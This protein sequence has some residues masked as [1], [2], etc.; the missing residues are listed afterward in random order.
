LWYKVYARR[1]T[2]CYHYNWMPSKRVLNHT[3]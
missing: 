1:D 3:K 2:E